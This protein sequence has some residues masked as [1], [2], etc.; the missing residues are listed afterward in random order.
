LRVSAVTAAQAWALRLLGEIASRSDPPDVEPAE[1]RDR[2]ALALAAELGMR[3]L[4][5][6]CHFGLG[7]L[8]RRTGKRERAQGAPH[9]SDD[10]VPGDG[11]ALLAGAGGGGNGWF[12][13]ADSV[14]I[15]PSSVYDQNPRFRSSRKLVILRGLSS[16]VRVSSKANDS[17]SVANTKP[18]SRHGRCQQVFYPLLL[19]RPVDGPS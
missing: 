12:L 8:Y 13:I 17:D 3:P 10:D 6:H 14:P 16:S 11:H 1:G 18:R 5:A 19:W 4:L 2:Q 15:Q 9:H 7:K